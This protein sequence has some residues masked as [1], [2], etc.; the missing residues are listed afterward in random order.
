MTYAM[1]RVITALEKSPPW[2][3]NLITFSDM[4]RLAEMHGRDSDV[5]IHMLSADITLMAKQR[6]DHR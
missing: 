5:R 3:H 4:L 2:V 6:R 1:N